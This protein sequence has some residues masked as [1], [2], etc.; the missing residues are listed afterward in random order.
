MERSAQADDT[1]I[2]ESVHELQAFIRHS[3][4][5]LYQYRLSP[6]S[7]GIN[8]NL[9]Q[10]TMGVQC[11]IYGIILSLCQIADEFPD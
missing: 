7:E 1:E 5:V 4:N 11:P 2:G 8:P 9:E 3:T 6:E 10:P